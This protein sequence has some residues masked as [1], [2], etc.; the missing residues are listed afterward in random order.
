MTDSARG[1]A[2]YWADGDWNAAC[3]VCGRKFKASTLRR[4]WQGY[5]VCAKDWEPRHPQDFVRGVQ[6]V[7]TVPWA[8][9]MTD[10]FQGYIAC[11]NAGG[12]A[13]AL[14]LTPTTATPGP[15]PGQS[16]QFTATATNTGAATATV[17]GTVVTIEL[18]GAALVAGDIVSGTV[19]VLTY[20]GINL[21]FDLYTS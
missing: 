6:D 12:S 15:Y 14:T 1:K 2:D 7:Q 5:W 13:N 19:Y 3:Y 8:Q 16:F 17:N 9:P 11:G 21:V 18:A 4:H 10:T 20:D